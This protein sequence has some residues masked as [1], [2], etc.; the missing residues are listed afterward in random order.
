MLESKD[1]TYAI[2]GGVTKAGTTSLFKYM[3]MHNDVCCSSLKETRFFLDKSYPL[4]AP[5]YYEDTG[6]EKYLEFFRSDRRVYL[7]ATPDYLYSTGTPCRVGEALGVDNVRWIFLLRDPIDRLRSWYR[8]GIQVGQIHSRLSLTEYIESQMN[9]TANREVQ[10][11]RALEQGRYSDYLQV[12]K[13]TFGEENIQVLHFEK[14]K[15][16]PQDIVREVCQ[17]L[18]ISFDRFEG[19]NFAQHNPSISPKNIRLQAAYYGVGKFLYTRVYDKPLLRKGLRL[20]GNRIVEP[21][22]RFVNVVPG[23]EKAEIPA[24]LMTALRDYYDDYYGLS[25]GRPAANSLK[26]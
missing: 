22:Y 21:V 20:I 24:S 8:F 18:A 13:D 19:R 2:I 5:Y 12:Y 14:L 9:G 17:F 26:R 7:E 11:F 25:F 10:A 16:R 15:D 23:K 6:L 1:R 4:C 3:V